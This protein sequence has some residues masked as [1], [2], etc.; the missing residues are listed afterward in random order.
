METLTQN[1]QALTPAS[2][3]ERNL[4]SFFS[5]Q[6]NWSRARLVACSVEQISRDGFVIRPFGDV[7]KVMVNDAAEL[8][9][10]P[11]WDL[12]RHLKAWN[13]AAIA[14]LCESSGGLRPEDGPE[15]QMPEDDYWMMYWNQAA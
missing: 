10:V 3:A 15:A 11:S 13:L 7:G 12:K 9:G 2:P 5:E 8:I 6:D 4:S 1:R 14:G